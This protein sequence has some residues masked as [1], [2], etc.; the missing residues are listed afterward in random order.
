M[1]TYVRIAIPLLL[2]SA[3]AA[4]AA[5]QT[6]ITWSTP[7]RQFRSSAGE[8]ITLV[9]PARGQFAPVWGSM[10]YTDD[11]SI[12]TAAV[13]AGAIR[14]ETGGPVMFRILPGRENYSAARRNGVTS[15]RWGEWET[16]FSVEAA[17]KPP[18][19]SEPEPPPPPPPRPQV[20]SWEQTAGR[21]APN[22]RRFTFECPARGEA[23]VVKGRDLYSWDSS[24]CTAAVHAGAIT[25]ER[26][27]I[28]TVEMRPGLRTYAGSERNGITS[29]A[30]EHTTLGFIVLVRR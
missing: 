28:V 17:P 20:I 14:A 7:G 10:I 4:T 18:A 26:G 8:P 5:A 23:A 6:A 2:S 9:C 13:H 30:G 21:L 1:R 15:E 3:L 27:G 24:I 29:T 22:G 19:H 12:C 11:S 25:L 16:S